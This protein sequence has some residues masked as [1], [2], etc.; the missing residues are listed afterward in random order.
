MEMQAGLG[1]CVE[2]RG[3][4]GWHGTRSRRLIWCPNSRTTIL[5][6]GSSPGPDIDEMASHQC[7]WDIGDYARDSDMNGMGM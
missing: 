2:G 5:A 7:L 6:R 3:K 4:R 1:E